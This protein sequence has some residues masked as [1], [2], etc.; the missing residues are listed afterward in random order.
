MSIFGIIGLS[1]LITLLLV[2]IFMLI[3]TI[4]EP[5]FSSTAIAITVGIFCALFVVFVFVGVMINTEQE[6]LY[7][8]EY[9]TQKVTIEQSLESTSLSDLARTDLVK[10]AADLNGELAARKAKYDRWHYVMFGKDV[11]DN[12]EFI[13]FN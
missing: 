1:F 2:A 13:S 5:D 6:L 3:V 7:I 11:Y 9:E 10:K 8:A 4:T 12:V